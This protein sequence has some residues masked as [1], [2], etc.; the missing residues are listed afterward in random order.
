MQTGFTD[1]EVVNSVRID[2]TR[3]RPLRRMNKP[4]V[5]FFEGD[6]VNGVHVMIRGDDLRNNQ[7]HG[8]NA[9]LNSVKI[10]L[11]DW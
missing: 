1:F 10:S 7:N 11:S 3:F 6:T 4:D 5:D 9:L 2:T 8:A